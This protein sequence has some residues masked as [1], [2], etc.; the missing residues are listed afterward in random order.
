[1]KLHFFKFHGTGN[2]FILADAR[3]GSF[4]PGKDAVVRLCDRHF[5]IGADGL[6]LLQSADGYDFGMAYYNSD[7]NE[8]TMCGNGGRCITAFAKRLGIIEE[9]ARFLAIDGVHESVILSSDGD[10]FLV[11]V[12]LRDATV[13]ASSAIGTCVNTGSP[14]LVRFVPEASKVDVV[15]EG[16]RIRFGKKFAET[17][18][19]VDF[20]EVAR[21]TLHVRTYERGV[22]NETLSC[23][24]GAT[25]VALVTASKFTP[26]RGFYTVH[27]PGGTLKVSFTQ[28]RND[29]TDVWLEGPVVMVFEGTLNDDTF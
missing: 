26:A 15:R 17:G 10:H 21:D 2:D 22:E 8:S 27:T 3:G 19:N 6:I 16:R 29:F 5:G 23:G 28:N 24:T 13:E 9:K 4:S 12:Q 7:G 18:V 1:M 14:H 25:A 11:K 20:V